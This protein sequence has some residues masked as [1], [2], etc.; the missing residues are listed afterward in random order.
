MS[1]YYDGDA[2]AGFRVVASD[3]LLIIGFFLAGA[4]LLGVVEDWSWTDRIYFLSVT[5]STTGY[6]DLIVK[7]SRASRLVCTLLIIV[8]VTLVFS[9]IK[10]YALAFHRI[11]QIVERRLLHAMGF[12]TTELTELPIARYSPSRVDKMANYPRQYIVALLPLVLLT[13][14]CFIVAVMRMKLDAID[15]LYFTIVTCTTV[16]YGDLSPTG[17]LDRAYYSAFLLLLVCAM[18]NTVSEII[19]INTRRGVRRGKL[20]QVDIE[21]LILHKVEDNP[22]DDEEPVVTESEYIVES[23]LQGKLVD[24]QIIDS[25]RRAYYWTAVNCQTDQKC[26]MG[27][28][29]SNI[30]ENWQQRTFSKCPSSIAET[31]HIDIEVDNASWWRR[32]LLTGLGRLQTKAL[33]NTCTSSLSDS[34]YYQSYQAWRK[35]YWDLRV[36]MARSR[37]FSASRDGSADQA[38]AY[39]TASSGTDTPAS[40]IINNFGYQPEE[41]EMASCA[42]RHEDRNEASLQSQVSGGSIDSGITDD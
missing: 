9:V 23:L 11:I 1:L 37:G 16:G 25:V 4:L 39:G 21:K 20:A 22:F 35:S 40:A 15:A 27:I 26:I 36:E 24:K 14:M 10:K 33:P 5:A 7:P 2:G 3:I 18:S 13:V 41:K 38:C 19:A 29:A 8:G 30:Y 34:R 28:N 17:P 6:G 31:S 42:E 32:M 12:E